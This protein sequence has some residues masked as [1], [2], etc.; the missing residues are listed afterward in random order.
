MPSQG[1]EPKL[2]AI[3]TSIGKKAERMI[4]EVFSTLAF[5]LSNF[6]SP[7][8]AQPLVDRFDQSGALFADGPFDRRPD[9]LHG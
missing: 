2:L 5:L 1:S 8:E 3:F 9:H 6:A 7:G 4:P